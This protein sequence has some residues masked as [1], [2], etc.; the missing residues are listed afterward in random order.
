MLED[1]RVNILVNR[2][3]YFEQSKTSHTKCIIQ[4]NESSTIDL[5]ESKFSNVSTSHTPMFAN[6]Y[7]MF[8]NVCACICLSDLIAL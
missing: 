4:R 3:V 7:Q 5:L 1:D 6:K 8:A 2:N